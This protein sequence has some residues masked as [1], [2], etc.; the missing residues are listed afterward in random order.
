MNDYKKPTNNFSI[1]DTEDYRNESVEYSHQTLVMKAMK[2]I[3]ELGGHE[4]SEGINETTIDQ[5]KGTTKIVYKE[6][7]KK[8]F[9]EAI[10]T[11]K[12]QMICDFD[13]E[14]K[15]NIPAL[16]KAMEEVKRD[17]LKAQWNFWGELT[18]AQRTSSD[19]IMVLKDV[20]N[21][22]LHFE[23]M[24]KD[25][26]IEIYRLIYEELVLLTCRLGFYQGEEIEG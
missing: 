13:K 15:T 12:M 10:K 9:I 1:E 2:R 22:K 7:T 26:E 24:F 19:A 3:I 14:A 20:F 11:A 4:L 17:G 8:A 21:P 23:R 5:R 25:A 18:P 6:D 16:F